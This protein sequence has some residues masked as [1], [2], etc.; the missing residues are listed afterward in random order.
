MAKTK[1]PLELTLEQIEI[2]GLLNQKEPIA[3]FEFQR[4]LQGHGK[5]ILYSQGKKIRNYDLRT[6]EFIE[7]TQKPRTKFHSPIEAVSPVL[8][9]SGIQHLGRNNFNQPTKR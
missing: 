7:Y 1:K 6:G 9:T 8:P 2:I 5:H 4:E 3:G